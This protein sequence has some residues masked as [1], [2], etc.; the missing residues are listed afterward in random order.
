[1]RCPSDRVLLDKDIDLDLDLDDER[2][3]EDRIGIREGGRRPREVRGSPK[4]SG[5]SKNGLAEAWVLK[6]GV[7]TATGGV[8]NDS[9]GSGSAWSSSVKESFLGCGVERRRLG[10]GGFRGDFDGRGDTGRRLL[11]TVDSIGATDGSSGVV[12]CIGTKLSS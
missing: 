3:R 8:E 1:M 7:E 10:G 6:P 11:K 4:I 5:V 12:G 9:M 2:R